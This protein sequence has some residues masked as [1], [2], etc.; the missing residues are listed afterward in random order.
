MKQATKNK[1]FIMSTKAPIDDV[2]LNRIEKQR[3]LL[4]NHNASM[5][6]NLFLTHE[7]NH[8]RF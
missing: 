2:A 3:L 5:T 7:F 6:G 4:S 8:I 1:P